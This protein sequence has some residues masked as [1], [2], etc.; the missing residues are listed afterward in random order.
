MP[1]YEPLT[2]HLNEIQQS[3]HSMSFAEI[4]ELLHDRLPPSA[5]K[6]R[7]WWSNNPN[8]S[9]MTKAW[10]DA[11]WISCDV[12][13]TK[14]RLVFKRARRS[15]RPIS[16]EPYAQQLRPSD[17]QSTLHAITIED[18]GEETMEALEVKARL[19]GKTVNQVARHILERGAQLT[20]ADRLALADRIRSQ[21]PN[22]H[23]VDVVGMIREDRDER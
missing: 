1:K 19:A 20:T 4:E 6:Y 2:T 5:Y 15:A 23:H 12:D 13:M 17:P 3:E 10:L 22:L 8:N 18:I 16:R 21:S 7:A 11:G 14:K 9:V